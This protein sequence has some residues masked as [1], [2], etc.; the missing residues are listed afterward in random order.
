MKGKQKALSIEPGADRTVLNFNLKASESSSSLGNG[1]DSAETVFETSGAPNSGPAQ[2]TMTNQNSKGG[3]R[4]RHSSETVLDLTNDATDENKD[5]AS[6]ISNLTTFH[7][8]RDYLDGAPIQSQHATLSELVS[9]SLK[10]LLGRDV[11]IDSLIEI[12]NSMLDRVDLN[13]LQDGVAGICLEEIIPTLR[14]RRSIH[15]SILL[16]FLACFSDACGIKRELE[17]DEPLFAHQTADSKLPPVTMGDK[18]RRRSHNRRNFNGL[19]P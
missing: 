1:Q 11:S 12:C 6:V 14:H 18:N 16:W 2:Q 10:R 8:I 9:E 5:T 19:Y 17:D 7:P 15:M 4:K 13:T 3:E